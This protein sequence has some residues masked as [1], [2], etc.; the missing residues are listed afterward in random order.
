[1]SCLRLDLSTF[2]AVYKH[3]SILEFGK[4]LILSKICNCGLRLSNIQNL[5]EILSAGTREYVVLSLINNRMTFLIKFGNIVLLFNK[6]KLH[7][8]NAL[9]NF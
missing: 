8:D 6:L 4:R 5:R 9:E 3:K 1:M 2:Y 7:K